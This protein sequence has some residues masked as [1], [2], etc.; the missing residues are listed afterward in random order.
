R[1][2]YIAD[3]YND[4]KNDTGKIDFE[5]MLFLGMK[6]DLPVSVLL[7]DEV[8][9]NSALLWSVIDAW[10]KPVGMSVMAGDP[11]QAI[12]LFSGASPDLFRKRE[13]TWR[14]IGNSHRLSARTAEF[15]LSLLRAA[16]YEN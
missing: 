6:M 15:A 14:T 10:A 5:D 13:G 8:Q 11:W 9:D 12:Y 16:G 4:F 3:R 1:L 7:C 2:S